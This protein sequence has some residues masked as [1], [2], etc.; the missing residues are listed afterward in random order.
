MPTWYSDVC[1]CH[2]I[3]TIVNDE[4]IGEL[5]EPCSFH[6]NFQETLNTNRLKNTSINT[7]QELIDMTDKS[8]SFSFDNGELTLHLFNFTE[9]DIEI[10]NQLNLAVNISEGV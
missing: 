6:K 3:Y 5:V 10:I 2:S 1:N 7:I 4:M 8:I 9:S